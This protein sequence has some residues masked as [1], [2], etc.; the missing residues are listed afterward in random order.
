MSPALSR[1]DVPPT[2]LLQRGKLPAPRLA[3]L[4]LLAATAW[5]VVALVGTQS[6][7]AEPHAMSLPPPAAAPSAIDVAAIQRAN[8]FGATSA[9]SAADITTSSE[10]F[11]AGVFSTGDPQA[12]Y[13]MLGAS[14]NSVAVY[15]TGA[16]VA[17]GTSLHAVYGD[18]VLLERAGQLVKLQLPQR[19]LLGFTSIVPVALT[20]TAQL[21]ASRPARSIPRPNPNVPLTAGQVLRTQ[22]VRANGKLQGYRLFPGTEQQVFLDAG[23]RTGDVVVAV[24]G[25]RPGEPASDLQQVLGADRSARVTI[26]RGGV[27]QELMV[28]LDG[29]RH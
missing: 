2:L 13:A 21:M 3:L 7:I 4:L 24:N 1:V 16:Q 20:P 23:L 14:V 28:S 29:H 15:R 9:A 27:R 10:F 8:L 5:R 11:L 26:L 25:R 6:T 18:H 19:P 12:G 22:V 17:A